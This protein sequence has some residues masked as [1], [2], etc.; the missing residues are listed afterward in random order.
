MGRH[1][2]TLSDLKGS[3]VHAIHG[4]RMGPFLILAGEMYLTV[5]TA[6]KAKACG[7]DVSGR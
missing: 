5:A 3:A 2:T 1:C 6:L 4:Q 7:W